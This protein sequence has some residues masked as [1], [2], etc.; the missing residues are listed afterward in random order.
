MLVRRRRRFVPEHAAQ[1]QEQTAKST[2]DK[3]GLCW[4]ELDVQSVAGRRALMNAI[5]SLGELLRVRCCVSRR[6]LNFL[7]EKALVARQQQQQRMGWDGTWMGN[8]V[9]RQESSCRAA[10][11]TA[12]GAPSEVGAAGNT[13]RKPQGNF[14]REWGR[15]GW[16]APPS[17]PPQFPP[18]LVPLT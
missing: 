9:W 4:H 16:G 10:R 2:P 3:G 11:L 15:G 18:P 6:Q 7:I 17:C 13:R 1:G 12:T 5:N 14:L 8:I